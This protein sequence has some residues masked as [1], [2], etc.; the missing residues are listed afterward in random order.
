MVLKCATNKKRSTM[1][2]WNKR[3]S[4]IN[5]GIAWGILYLHEDSIFRIFHQDLKVSNTLLDDDMDPKISDFGMARIFG[6]NQAQE[7]K[8]RVVGN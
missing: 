4:I 7:K 8:N 6:K 5:V 2:D 3:F 1:L